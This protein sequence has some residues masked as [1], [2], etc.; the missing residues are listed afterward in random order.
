M[1][2]ESKQVKSQRRGLVRGDSGAKTPWVEMDTILPHRTTREQQA[3]H[4]V[5]WVNEKLRYGRGKFYSPTHTSRLQLSKKRR[6]SE[7]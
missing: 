3:V 7:K 5:L 2:R 4:L 6:E 1:E